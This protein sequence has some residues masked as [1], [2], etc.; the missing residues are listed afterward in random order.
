LAAGIDF[1]FSEW[2][3][4]ALRR[5]WLVSAELLNPSPDIKDPT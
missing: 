4:E 2:L 1:D 3:Q 5:T